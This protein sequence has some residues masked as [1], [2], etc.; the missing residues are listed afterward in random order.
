MATLKSPVGTEIN[1]T[2]E[3]NRLQKFKSICRKKSG[4]SKVIRL[5]KHSHEGAYWAQGSSKLGD[6]EESDTDITS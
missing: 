2:S 4:I 1:S 5:D 3:Y 6:Y